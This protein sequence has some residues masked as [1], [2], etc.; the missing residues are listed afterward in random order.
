MFFVKTSSGTD[1]HFTLTKKKHFV[2]LD[3]KEGEK[4]RVLQRRNGGYV[5]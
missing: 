5:R 3:L 2:I 4:K 1:V